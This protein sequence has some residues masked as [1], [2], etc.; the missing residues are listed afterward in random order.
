VGTDMTSEDQT[1]AGAWQSL[2]ARHGGAP[3]DQTW[4]EG[5]PSWLSPSLGEWLSVQL[6]S[7]R[8]RNRLFA[9]LHRPDPYVDPLRSL[10]GDD[11]SLLDGIDGVLNLNLEEKS[12][13]LAVEAARNL[14]ARLREGNSIWKVSDTLDALERR[15]DATVTAAVRQA[16]DTASSSGRPAASDHLRIAWHEIYGLHPDPSKA[17]SE[18]ILAVEAVAVPVITPNQVDATL[19]HVYGQLRNQSD[20]YELAITDKSGAPASVQPVTELVGLLWHGHTDRHEGNVPAIPINPEAAQM[21]VHAAATL[22]Q[23]FASGA[24][25]RKPTKRRGS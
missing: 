17:F 7:E 20:L 14:E 3:I 12:Y 5:V 16:S 8:I 6:R 25:R 18:A 1:A 21:A 9:R 22:V 13:N 24:V 19:G 15:Q 10:D 2:S 23:W 4:H 11:V